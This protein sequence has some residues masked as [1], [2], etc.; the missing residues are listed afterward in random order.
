MRYDASTEEG[1][2]SGKASVTFLRSRIWS[3]W[4]QDKISQDLL[5]AA[6]CLLQS[7]ETK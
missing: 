2:G 5:E 7:M 4:A 6:P 1:K 3:W